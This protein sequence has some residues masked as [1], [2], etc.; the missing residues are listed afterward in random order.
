MQLGLPLTQT[1]RSLNCLC[2]EASKGEAVCRA[3]LICRLF[4]PRILNLSSLHLSSHLISATY[5]STFI[6]YPSFP[7]G[8]TRVKYRDKICNSI[9]PTFIKFLPSLC[10]KFPTNPSPNF[11]F[12]KNGLRREI[13]LCS[14]HLSSVDRSVDLSVQFE[15]LTYLRSGEITFIE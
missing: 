9:L 15:R 12:R 10:F 7:N 13:N 1:R 6:F 4:P 5:A 3:P 14:I 11:S 2:S 8:I